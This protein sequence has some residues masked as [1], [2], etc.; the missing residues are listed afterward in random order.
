M[1]Y[2][3]GLKLYANKLTLRDVKRLT[4]EKELPFHCTILFMLQIK[5]FII[6]YI[7]LKTFS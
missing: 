3:I 2:T 7:S 1:T 6:I 5:K 4:G